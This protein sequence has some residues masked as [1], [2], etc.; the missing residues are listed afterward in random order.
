MISSYVNFVSKK[1][2]ATTTFL[3][4]VGSNASFTWVDPDFL[5]ERDVKPWTNIPLWWPPRNDWG[6]RSFGGITGGVGAFA[7]DGSAAR[8]QGLTHTPLPEIARDTLNWYREAFRGEWPEDQRPG[9]TTV[10][11][12]ELLGEWHA[13]R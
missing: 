7:I 9:L 6:G 4:S 13:T 12:S 11:E 1:C 2:M 8:A 10:R 5:F 3:Y